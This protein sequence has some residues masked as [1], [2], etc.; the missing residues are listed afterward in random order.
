MRV[1]FNWHVVF[2]KFLGRRGKFL[3]FEGA[4]LSKLTLFGLSA[5]LPAQHQTGFIWGMIYYAGGFRTGISAASAVAKA[6]LCASVCSLLCDDSCPGICLAQRTLRNCRI[7]TMTNMTWFA[8][9]RV[10]HGVALF[11][12]HV[13]VT[14]RRFPTVTRALLLASGFSLLCDN[15]SFPGRRLC[16]APPVLCDHCHLQYDPMTW[17]VSLAIFSSVGAW[18]IRSVSSVNL[19]L[20]LEE[21][22]SHTLCFRITRRTRLCIKE[23]LLKILA[24][25]LG[26]RNTCVLC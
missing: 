23:E 7:L 25:L 2:P 8:E 17:V 1:S 16:L 6:V 18:C 12:Q 15:V 3:P 22:P 20:F 19:V 13:V 5:V 9:T 11:L 26:Q 4:K 14:E 10:S 24:A 21:G